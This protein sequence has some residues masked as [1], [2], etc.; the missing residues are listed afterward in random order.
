MGWFTYLF[1]DTLPPPEEPRNTP[2]P[3]TME[4]D[5]ITER[6]MSKVDFHI[7]RFRRALDQCTNPR[8]KKEL[9]RN[10]KYWTGVKNLTRFAG[11]ES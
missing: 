1:N 7:A 2:Q 5:G 11:D 3:P 8:K 6:S 9:E 10:L 4:N